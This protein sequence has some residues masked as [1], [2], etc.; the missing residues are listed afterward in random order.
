MNKKF[1]YN[2]SDLKPSR[3]D[4]MR[5]G[6]ASL[7]AAMMMRHGLPPFL[8]QGM[9]GIPAELHPGSPN[10]PRGWTTTLP[11][12]PEGMPVDPPVTI[13]G[14]RRGPWE[15][16]DGDDI[17]NSPFTRLN[18][19]V[20]GI[21]WKLAFTWTDNE[22]EVLQKYNLAIASDE[23]PDFM[24][25]V[26]LQ[27]YSELLE[28]DLI[29]DITEVWDEVAHPVWLKEAMSFSDGIAWRLAEVNGRKMG[30]PYIEQAAQND[31]VLWIR[32]DW[33]DAVGMS[34][35]TTIDELHA[36]MLP[37]LWKRIWAKAARARRSASPPTAR[38][39]PGIARW[40]P[41]S[42]PGA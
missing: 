35:P 25:T 22:G 42:A 34:A 24:E 27:I 4:F 19:A 20:T 6:G 29:E 26:P 16:A 41:S 21:N 14:S 10:N 37:L 17:E 13:T 5:L 2:T 39:T 3:R 32:Q 33:L 18:A 7:A 31:K 28:N 36:V 38:S 9:G 8:A 11:P 30:V 12:I 1:P 40:I 23:L 15:F